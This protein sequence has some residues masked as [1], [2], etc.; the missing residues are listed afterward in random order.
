MGFAYRA[1]KTSQRIDIAGNFSEIS[2]KCVVSG[3]CSLP[4]LWVADSPE[5]VERRGDPKRCN[6]LAYQMER[7]PP[8][9][10][11]IGGGRVPA[12]LVPPVLDAAFDERHS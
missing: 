5:A 2:I 9:L 1:I 10:A 4:A 8:D 12:F 3:N 6:G 11:E 7:I